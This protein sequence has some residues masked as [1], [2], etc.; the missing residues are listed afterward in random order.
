MVQ[1]RCTFDR[2][3]IPENT[4]RLLFQPQDVRGPLIKLWPT[5]AQLILFAFQGLSEE[6]VF[7]M[8]CR[9]ILHKSRSISIPQT[10]QDVRYDEIEPG[11]NFGNFEK[12]SKAVIA[13]ASRAL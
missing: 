8:P 7:G 5:Y 13:L 12:S 6:I 3:L 2:F 10:V 11:V 9:K 1:C 4:L